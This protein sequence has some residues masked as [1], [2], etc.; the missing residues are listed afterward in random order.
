[1]TIF[2]AITRL[3]TGPQITPEER[4]KI[5]KER[6]AKLFGETINAEESPSVES[7]EA[8]VCGVVPVIKG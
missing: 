8:S 4:N 2:K 3:W 6:I 1:M 5:L 7:M